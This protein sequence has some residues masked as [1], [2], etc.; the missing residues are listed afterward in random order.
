MRMTDVQ[1]VGPSKTSNTMSK[2]E[3][4]NDDIDAHDLA[5]GTNCCSHHVRSE[6][7]GGKKVHDRGNKYSSR[8]ATGD[9]NID[10]GTVQ[11]DTLHWIDDVTRCLNACISRGDAVKAKG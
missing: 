4:H 1:N 6:M 7:C 8:T 3:N 9:A 2:T 5:G 10:N 11:N